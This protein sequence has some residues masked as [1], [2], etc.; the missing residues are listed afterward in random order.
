MLRMFFF[1]SISL[2]RGP[3]TSLSKISSAQDSAKN[4]VFHISS[5]TVFS[6]LLGFGH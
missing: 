6:R 5:L 4:D 3:V 1:P 2:Q